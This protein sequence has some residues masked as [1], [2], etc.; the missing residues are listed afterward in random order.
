MPCNKGDQ[1]ITHGLLKRIP[2]NSLTVM[3]CRIR[4]EP[5]PGYLPRVSFY[6][7]KVCKFYWTCITVSGVSVSSVRLSH[8]FPELPYVLHASATN[9][10]GAGT[11]SFHLPGKFL[12]S[13][14]PP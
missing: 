7:Q 1:S 9:A 2:T 11:A 5:H 6:I 12:E 8:P 4:T 13:V 14:R 3:F 10:R